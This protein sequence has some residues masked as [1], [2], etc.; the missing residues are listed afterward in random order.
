MQMLPRRHRHRNRNTDTRQVT[1][2]PVRT[3]LR[4]KT[5]DLEPSSVAQVVVRVLAVVD[6]NLLMYCLSGVIV[7]DCRGKGL[8]CA[9]IERETD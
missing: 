8:I 9:E 2:E 5:G 3:N 1:H 6:G 4:D 7:V